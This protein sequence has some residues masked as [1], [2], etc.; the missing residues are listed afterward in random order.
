MS[1]ID[2][3]LGLFG[4]NTKKD[5][6]NIIVFP[7]PWDVTTSYQPGTHLGPGAI[8]QAS[9]QLDLYHPQANPKWVEQVAMAPISEKC[10]ANNI[11]LRPI[12]ET[13]IKAHDEGSYRKYNAHL[14]TKI[15]QVNQGCESLTNWVS[16]ETTTYLDQNKTVILLGGEHGVSLGLIKALTKKQDTFGI[17]QIDA[18]MDLRN[19]Y[20]GF[21]H[22]H[23][24]VMYNVLQ[25]SQVTKL[26][27][28]G[29]RDC[30]EEE[31]AFVQ[32]SGGRV[33]TFRDDILKEKQF[34]GA[35]WH[36]CCEEIIETLPNRVYISFDIDGLSPE[37]CPNTGTPVPGGLGFEE[38][39]YLLW[40]LK[41][42]GKKI[43]GADL[44]EVAP[45]LSQNEWDGNVGARV[46][47]GLCQLF[48]DT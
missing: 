26:V 28:V 38:V 34:R 31:V 45:G 27:Q 25:L 29:V 24:S 13:I 23:A 32:K 12:A 5:Q 11:T 48:S 6:A 1:E 2:S 18:H 4:L 9:S 15:D 10:L 8:L 40:Q 46:L 30:C 44:V 41:K 39:Q 7:V 3:K 37:L 47:M 36:D 19:A 43:I 21:T 16:Q 33:V 14:K 17:L 35:L 20:Q 22:S 42:S